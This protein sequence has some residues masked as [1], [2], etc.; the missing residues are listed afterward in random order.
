M[1]VS[2]VL[3]RRYLHKSFILLHSYYKKYCELDRTKEYELLLN[4]V[5]LIFSMVDLAQNSSAR[6]KFIQSIRIF[7]RNAMPSDLDVR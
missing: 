7:V 2:L 1:K 4:M 6:C 3:S 5:F